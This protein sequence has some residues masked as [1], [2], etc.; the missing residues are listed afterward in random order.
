MTSNTTTAT[1]SIVLT[2]N[3]F[4]ADINLLTAKGSKLYL[5]AIEKLPKLDRIVVSLENRSTVRY[6]FKLYQS[7]FALEYLLSHVPDTTGVLGDIIKHYQ[8][9][10]IENI[11]VLNIMYLEDSTNAIL[12]ASRIIPNLDPNVDPTN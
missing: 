12:L 3:S 4:A 6:T 1:I 2:L 8:I 9:F 11:L 5:K 10:L 7:K